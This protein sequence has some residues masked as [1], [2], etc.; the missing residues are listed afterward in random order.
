MTGDPAFNRVALLQRILNWLSPVPGTSSIELDSSAYALPSLITVEVDAPDLVGQGQ[1]TVRFTNLTTGANMGAAALETVRP[2]LFRGHIVLVATN[3]G[4]SSLQLPAHNGDVLQ[5]SFVDPTSGNLVTNRAV[6]DTVPPVISNVA[7]EPSYLSAII[8]WETS[9]EADALVQFGESTFLSHSAYVSDLDFFQGVELDGL[10]PDRMY[11]YQV[12]S[13][14]LA[15][16]VAVDDNGGNLYTFRTL[17]PIYP[18]WSDD[19]E[20][21]SGDWSVIDGDGTES[22]WQLGAPVPVTAHSPPTA[23]SSDLSGAQLSQSE[24]FLV[25]PAIDLSNGNLATLRFW[26]NYDFTEMEWDIM[27]YGE[28]LLITNENVTP[29]TLDTVMDFSTGW[30]LAEYDLTPYLGNVVYVAFHYVLFSMDYYP[31]LGWLVDDVSVTTSN[32]IPGTILITN[33]LF[34]AAFTLTGPIGRTGQGTSLFVSNALPGEYVVSFQPVPFYQ[35]PPSLTNTLAGL[36]L[37]VFPGTYTFADTNHN[38]L[39]DAWESRFFGSAQP[40]HPG[41]LDTDGDGMSDAAEFLAGTNPN[42]PASRLILTTP[43]LHGGSTLTLNWPTVLGHGYCVEVTTN[44]QTWT[45]V[46][47]WERAAG[48]TGSF[49]VPEVTSPPSVFYRV[50]VAP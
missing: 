7:V 42:D 33:N 20:H 32:L 41:S 44:L 24:T 5:V 12:V 39:S 26:Q 36:Q 49:V 40:V 25:S 3:G 34:Q 14:D 22:T 45:Q 11:Y 2:G 13:R 29:I 27:H 38:G 28:L 16:N 1:T 30:E 17:R 6:V 21:G 19:L 18:P 48:A 46:R 10:Q 47:D 31:R 43:D 37:L 35:T 4:N 50:R 8:T 9:K 15:G 23:W